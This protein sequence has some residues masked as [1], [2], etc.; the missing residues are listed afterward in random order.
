MSSCHQFMSD[1]LHLFYCPLPQDIMLIGLAQRLHQQPAK[2]F[3]KQSKVQ[4]N[5]NTDK[6]IGSN[7]RRPAPR[8]KPN[9]PTGLAKKR[10]ILPANFTALV[11][12]HRKFRFCRKVGAKR[13]Y[14]WNFVKNLFLRFCRDSPGLK[15]RGTNKPLDP[16]V[17]FRVMDEESG[18]AP[19]SPD[20]GQSQAPFP[21]HTGFSPFLVF[22]LS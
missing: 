18:V 16:M 22:F 4:P 7:V 2:D 1:R 20:R 8:I 6:N 5:F 19:I 14:A 12:S 17:Y 21:S 9:T 3:R 11:E 13:L 15:L 10:G